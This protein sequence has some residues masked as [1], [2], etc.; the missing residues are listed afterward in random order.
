MQIQAARSILATDRPRAD[1]TLAKAQQLAQE[2]LGDV[3][4]SVS[5]LRVAPAERQSLPVALAE[6]ADASHAAGLP[7]TVTVLGDARSLD[8][9][10]EQALTARRRRASQMR[11]STPKQQAPRS[12][13]I[14]ATPATCG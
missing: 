1:Q 9:Q 8:P 6:L 10:E 3:R 14:S 11:A 2:A 13:S 7:T 4:R 5:A 12:H